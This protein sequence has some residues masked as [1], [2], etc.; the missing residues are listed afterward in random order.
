MFAVDSSLSLSLSLSL[1]CF[2]SSTLSF[3]LSLSLS[4]PLSP[5]PFPLS[6]LCLSCKF[7]MLSSFAGIWKESFVYQNLK[8]SQLCWPHTRRLSRPMVGLNGKHNLVLPL[9]L[10]LS[11]SLSF[12]PPLLTSFI[13]SSILDRA[14]VEHNILSASRLYNSITF[15]ELG[16]LLG[17]PAQKVF[18]HGAHLSDPLHHFCNT[19]IYRCADLTLVR[20]RKLR[21]R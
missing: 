19:A 4:F 16:T 14:V 13:G 7:L 2:L 9:S 3:S 10:S 6:T 18:F 15:E 17:I 20:R 12:S 21:Q 5:F 1:F 8:A 11:L